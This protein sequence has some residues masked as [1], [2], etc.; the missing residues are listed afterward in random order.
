[1]SIR[2]KFAADLLAV[3]VRLP[4]SISPDCPAS[5]IDA[6]GRSFATID[7]NRER[8]DA[9]AIKMALW[10]ILAVNTCGGHSAPGTSGG[11]V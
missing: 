5:I 2:E 11:S 1:M 4:L 6:D 9:E 10:T 7:M 8:P 3:N